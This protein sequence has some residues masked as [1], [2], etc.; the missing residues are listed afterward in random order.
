LPPFG[1][2]E[3][4]LVEFEQLRSG[5]LQLVNKPTSMAVEAM[6]DAQD[7][8]SVYVAEVCVFDMYVLMYCSV[9]HVVYSM[10]EKKTG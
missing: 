7:H 1:R 10:S 4:R 8:R 9:L 6:I 2:I 5:L 3:I